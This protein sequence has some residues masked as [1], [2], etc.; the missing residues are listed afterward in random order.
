MFLSSSVIFSSDPCLPKR[1]RG[2]PR[3][4]RHVGSG[5]C[6][7]LPSLASQGQHHP[8]HPPPFMWLI[9]H[10]A[11]KLKSI[12]VKRFLSCRMN[13]PCSLGQFLVGAR[14]MLAAVTEGFQSFHMRNISFFLTK[15]LQVAYLVVKKPHDGSGTWFRSMLGLF[16]V[17]YMSLMIFIKK[18]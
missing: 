4:K 14:A 10:H 12:R 1:A 17:F 18:T 8:P 6:K 9:L 16:P 5:F 2:F 7:L 11:R 15:K 13:I 3:K